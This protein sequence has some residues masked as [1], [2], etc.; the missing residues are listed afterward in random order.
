MA[1]KLDW[2]N[3]HLVLIRYITV[4]DVQAKENYKI[5]PPLA[6]DF[7]GVSGAE[8]IVYKLARAEKFKE[9]CEFLAY[10]A[11]RRA[12]V[13]WGYRC[14]LSLLEELKKNPVT[15]RDI[16]DIAADFETTVPDWAKVEM[17][18]P[19]DTSELDAKIAEL[20]AKNKELEKQLD[21]EIFGLVQEAVEFAFQ[22]FKK[23]HG[24]H[25][26]DLLKKLGEKVKQEQMVVDPKS[27]VFTAEA[28][29]K[30]K[31]Q[32][33]QKET[34]DTIKSVLPPKVPAHEK[35]LRDD[36]LTASYRWVA[37]PDAENSQKCLD[38][39]NEC[40]D[41]PAGLL[42][43]SAF[44]AYGSLMPTGDQA[45]P[46]PPGLAANGLNQVL[47]MCSLHKGGTRKVKERYEEYFRLGI[48]VLTGADNWEGTL[49]E[50]KMPHEEIAASAGIVG[51]AAAADKDAAGKDP[52]S[53]AAED[54]QEPKAESAAP[55]NKDAAP[56]PDKK[57][58]YKRWKPD[59]GV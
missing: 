2:L 18:P 28:E 46:T 45:V 37:A 8:E 3:Q 42:S 54:A 13:W 33:V 22:E 39:G 11:H 20:Q 35:K 7:E 15:E 24:I 32:A 4:E 26:V 48:Q 23:V 9:A 59:G 44:W 50:K 58:A 56:E 5:P 47:L 10:I 6:G 38:I 17:P 29:L 14:V 40:P 51:S 21:P 31:L 16:A 49:A 53:S 25:P 41:T 12:G 19:V 1:D 36:A 30:A 43:L 27:P 52:A 55:E 34:V 57:N